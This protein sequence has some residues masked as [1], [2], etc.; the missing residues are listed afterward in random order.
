[1]DCIRRLWSALRRDGSC[2]NAVYFSD[3]GRLVI[4]L[5]CIFQANVAFHMKTSLGQTL[6]VLPWIPGADPDAWTPDAQLCF[7]GSVDGL[8]LTAQLHG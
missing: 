4:L 5:Q 7:A 8:P 1:M 6:A 3:T 2:P